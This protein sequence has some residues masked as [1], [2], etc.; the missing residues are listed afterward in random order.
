MYLVIRVILSTLIP[1]F[2]SL[3]VYT[4]MPNTDA[5]HK[6]YIYVMSNTFGL[7]KV[8]RAINPDQRRKGVQCSSGVP[9]M[10]E[11]KMR[12][13][14]LERLVHDALSEFRQKGEW[15]NCTAEHAI[16]VIKQIKKTMIKEKQKAVSREEHADL[17]T[18]IKRKRALSLPMVDPLELTA[19]QLKGYCK[20]ALE[21]LLDEVGNVSHLAKMLNIHYMTVRG[22][23]DRGRISK[24]GAVLVS[25][26]P[27]LAEYYTA[28]DLRPDIT[29][30]EI[31]QINEHLK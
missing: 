20:G 15:F 26:H 6:D 9:T 22:W 31:T 14:D 16:K 4:P 2:L 17:L 30:E 13:G 7:V 24:Q 18:G 25:L 3:T 27:T 23:K 11:F 29:A 21:I 28:Q 5:P 1:Y 19:L 10:L 12:N 8:G